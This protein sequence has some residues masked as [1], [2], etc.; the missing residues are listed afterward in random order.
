[1]RE[2]INETTELPPLPG[3]IMWIPQVESVFGLRSTPQLTGQRGGTLL[4][5]NKYSI[6]PPG[7]PRMP[8]ADQLITMC[9][10]ASTYSHIQQIH[11][12]NVSHSV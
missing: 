6:I 1:M 2:D 7:L 11:K 9:S 12:S 10:A 8:S 5:V 3:Q 4:P